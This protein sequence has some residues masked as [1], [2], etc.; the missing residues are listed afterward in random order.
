MERQRIN[1]TE[2][3]PIVLTSLADVFIRLEGQKS[4]G[5]F[6]V[7]GDAES[8]SGKTNYAQF[9]FKMQNR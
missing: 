6:R 3:L 7:P 5:I 9:R 2:E 4:E 1:S 8:V